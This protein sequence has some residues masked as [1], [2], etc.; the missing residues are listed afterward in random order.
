MNSNFRQLP[1]PSN[2]FSELIVEMLIDGKV[3]LTVDFIMLDNDFCEL[4]ISAFRE[5]R[6]YQLRDLE[7]IK[8]DDGFYF[9]ILFIAQIQEIICNMYK[10]SKLNTEPFI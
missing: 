2:H 7:I 8:R 6:R 9:S 5:E 1:L 3:I 10:A 4:K